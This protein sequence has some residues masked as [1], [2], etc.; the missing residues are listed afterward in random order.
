[1]YTIFV[2]GI[3]DNF[4]GGGGLG[5]LFYTPPHPLCASISKTKVKRVQFKIQDP[6][7]IPRNR[8]PQK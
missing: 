4:K 3:F 8:P 5:V 7:H 6:V 1:M 2:F